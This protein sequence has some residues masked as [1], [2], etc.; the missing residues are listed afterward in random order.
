M[1][2][3]KIRNNNMIKNNQLSTNWFSD[4]TFA[5]CYYF[6]I[7]MIVIGARTFAPAKMLLLYICGG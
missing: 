7:V 5:Y 4:E 1:T 2:L 6:K 3:E